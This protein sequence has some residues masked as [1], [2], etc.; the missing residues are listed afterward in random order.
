MTARPLGALGPL[1]A[2]GLAIGGCTGRLAVLDPAARDAQLIADWGWWLFGISGAI[3][4]AV[5]AALL[6]GMLRRRTPP[7]D[8]VHEAARERR[9]GWA[10]GA[11]VT[12]TVMVLFG[13]MV[14]SDAVG[15]S[16][17]WRAADGALAVKITGYQW[18]W[19]I[20]YQDPIASRRVTTANELHV[21]VGRDVALELTGGDVIHSFWVPQLNG[22]RDL[23]PG[24]TTE[25]VL[26]AD[27]PGAFRGQ[28]AEF[29]GFAH[30]HMGLLVIS[31]PA[32]EF[33]AWLERQRLPAAPPTDPLAARGAQLF[34]S[35]PCALCH[36]VRG[37]DAG[38]QTGPDLTHVASRQML[39]AAL[40]PNQIATL[41]AWTVAAPDLKPG[42]HMPAILLP[43]ADVKALVAYLLTLQ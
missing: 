16:T 28:C 20:E 12:A 22:K 15:R 33:E 37:S 14:A 5:M 30:S 18:W 39:G 43:P 19:K 27:R 42:V 36:A 29:C 40:L 34:A 1:G 31:E 6:F 23:I 24:H 25:L 8:A 9:A 13:L 35:G 17:G 3:Y 10:V 32:E 41:T 4:A 38:G 21:P 11:A 26:R 2:A 7:G